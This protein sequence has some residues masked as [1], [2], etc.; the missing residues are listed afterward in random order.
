MQSKIADLGASSTLRVEVV[1]FVTVKEP[2]SRSLWTYDMT[3]RLP[4]NVDGVSNLIFQMGVNYTSVMDRLSFILCMEQFRRWS[5]HLSPLSP[6]QV[7]PLGNFNSSSSSFDPCPAKVRV[8]ICNGGGCSKW[9]RKTSI[10]KGK[11]K[12]YIAQQFCSS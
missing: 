6:F 4:H 11:F 9:S 3:L 8:R 12:I 7:F 1:V 10:A 5:D 2:K